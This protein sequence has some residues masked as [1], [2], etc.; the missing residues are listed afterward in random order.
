MKFAVQLSG[1]FHSRS[2]RISQGRSANM[3][4][5]ALQ[6]WLLTQQIPHWR[7][8]HRY[9]RRK[10]CWGLGLKLCT[11]LLVSMG[12]SPSMNPV[13][14]AF[15]DHWSSLIKTA[16][17]T[18]PYSVPKVSNSRRANPRPKPNRQSPVTQ[19]DP[20]LRHFPATRSGSCQGRITAAVPTSILGI[21]GGKVGHQLAGCLAQTNSR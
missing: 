16:L 19:Y 15:N 21:L 8:R 3:I 9:D 6:V 18:R 11:G 2:S 17:W 10:E 1:T 7:Q 20:G 14:S 13:F 4:T 5:C 12:P